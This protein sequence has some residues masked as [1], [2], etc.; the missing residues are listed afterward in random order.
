MHT[1]FAPAVAPA[2]APWARALQLVWLWAFAAPAPA[3]FAAAAPAFAP[4][5]ALWA[6]DRAVWVLG[7]WGPVVP[8]PRGVPEVLAQ[9]FPEVLAQGFP[10]VLAGV[11][12]AQVFR[13]EMRLRRPPQAVRLRLRL[14]RLP[15]TQAFFFLV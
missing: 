1:A 2:F 6:V 10:E 13:L 12:L 11:L 9:G 14:L 3:A 4:A 5:F 7:S 8:A 15:V